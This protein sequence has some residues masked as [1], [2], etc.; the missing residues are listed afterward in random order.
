M[1]H[2]RSNKFLP[3]DPRGSVSLLP[4]SGV[5]RKQAEKMAF[6][7][8]IFSQDYE[9]LEREVCFSRACMHALSSLSLSQSLSHCL[10]LSLSLYLS[11]FLSIYFLS[12]YLFRFPLSLFLARRPAH[13]CCCC[14]A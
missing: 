10:S 7:V 3:M 8:V 9:T 4:R 13:Y 11:I 2:Q 14:F 12:L 5:S 1:Y 6:H